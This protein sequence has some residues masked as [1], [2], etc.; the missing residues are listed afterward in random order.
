MANT[1]GVSSTIVASRLSTAVISEAT[2]NTYA[3]RLR[4]RRRAA[5]AIQAPQA[6][7][8]PSSSHSRA[9]TSTAARNPITG[10]S[11]ATSARTRSSVIAPV[12]MTTPAAG[13]ATTASGRPRG[14]MTAKASTAR[15]RTEERASASKVF[16]ARPFPGIGGGETPK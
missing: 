13:T 9:S 5:R 16:K 10:P 2:A 1:T 14:R 6:W 12:A 8:S 7:N 15:S 4:G 11:R 3:R